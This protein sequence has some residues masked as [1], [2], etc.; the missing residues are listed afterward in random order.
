MIGKC[1]CGEES[2]RDAVRV[3]RTRRRG[4]GASA[5][6]HTL[7]WGKKPHWPSGRQASTAQGRRSALSLR[8]IVFR[9]SF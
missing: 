8:I 9:T 3:R 2:D 4:A 1:Q 7:C 5:R 6:G